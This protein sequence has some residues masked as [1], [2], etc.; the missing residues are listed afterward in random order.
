MTDNK[1]KILDYDTFQS[2][3]SNKT[4]KPANGL[5]VTLNNGAVAHYVKN[6]NG[7]LVFRI[8]KGV[9]NMD[10]IRKKALKVKREKLREKTNLAVNKLRKLYFNESK[11]PKYKW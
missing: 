7:D 3:K 9:K 2:L 10:K 6:I 4:W 8:K 5:M 11:K 1:G